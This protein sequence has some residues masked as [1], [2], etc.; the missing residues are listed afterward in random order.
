M[1]FSNNCQGGYVS[2][3]KPVVQS[4]DT[5]HTCSHRDPLTYETP[6][7]QTGR[8]G[9]GL[10]GQ[11]GHMSGRRTH[12]WK[13]G[14]SCVPLTIFLISEAAQKASHRVRTTSQHVTRRVVTIEEECLALHALSTAP[15]KS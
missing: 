11:D 4:R 10:H 7:G 6:I 13:N 1:Y 9:L 12:T 15:H 3:D 2:G 8:L 14:V 5:A